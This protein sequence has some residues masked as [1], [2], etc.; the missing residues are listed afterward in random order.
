M[1]S[2]S[3]P[4]LKAIELHLSDSMQ[5]VEILCDA[6]AMDLN[7]LMQVSLARV[8]RD[9]PDM[10]ILLT[11]LQ[12]VLGSLNICLCSLYALLRCK[13]CAGKPTQLQLLEA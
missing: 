11:S 13:N 4:L 5:R 1:Q 7:R 2:C 9:L 8:Q 6:R 3:H 12:G 10:D